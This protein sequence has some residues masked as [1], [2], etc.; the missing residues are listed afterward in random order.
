MREGIE[1]Q[2]ASDHKQLW[3]YVS[4]VFLFVTLFF[5]FVPFL[6]GMPNIGLDP[7]WQYAINQAVAQ[8]M[9]FGEDIIFTFG[10]Y[11]SI[12]TRVFHPETDTMMLLGSAYLAVCYGFVLILITT[13]KHHYWVLLLCLLMAGVM[14]SRD[15]LLF[16][17]PFILGLLSYKAF[18]EKNS[19]REKRTVFKIILFILISPLGLLPLIKGSLLILC[20]GILLLGI[21]VMVTKHYL[22]EVILAVFSFVIS[23]AFFW[24]MAGQEAVNLID[25][26]V[27]MASIIS[28]YAN[29][30]SLAGDGYE[31]VFYLLFSLL[32]LLAI[33]LNEK[34]EIDGRLYLVAVFFLFI[35]VSFKAGFIRHDG[36]HVMT[37]ASSILYLMMFYLLISYSY[38]LF[39]VV[40]LAIFV[41]MYIDSNHMA[42]SSNKVL[43]NLKQ[44]YFMSVHGF[45]KRLQNGC[46][47]CEQFLS[48]K[49]AINTKL[50]IPELDGGSDIYAYNQSYLIASDN[51]WQTRPVFQSYSAYSPVL[52]DINRDYLLSESAPD[53]IVFRLETIDNRF[54]AME[55]G[56][57]W[58]V[59][60]NSYR[61]VRR[62]KDYL[63]L[64][65][66]EKSRNGYFL[67]QLAENVHRFG[68]MIN[69]PDSDEPIFVKIDIKPSIIGRISSLFYKS[70]QVH[71]F[72]VMH[73]GS[74]KLFR[75]IPGMGSTGFMISPLVENN[76]DFIQLYGRG[77]NA[78]FSKV[79]SFVIVT[80]GF[81]L[82]CWEDAFKVSFEKLS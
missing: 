54:P 18:Y 12:Y 49:E 80:E 39:A 10:P 36:I 31:I 15:S 16:S 66:Q 45:N 64:T 76:D 43:D 77:E 68:D 37:V 50:T 74:K 59:L 63:Y 28:G 30:M 72:I 75:Y 42:T 67:Q 47:L 1:Q 79:K 2:P 19:W 9:A 61:P 55:E 26:L 13:N 32:V 25:Y 40:P 58:P 33:L 3:N 53:N 52:L 38:L 69:V 56:N 6:P 81:G 82:Q 17:Y 73:D 46:W 14:F 70:A 44:V 41:W 7:S 20:V 24:T 65:K 21:V 34:I 8:Q 35:F 23:M 22:T 78:T 29:A 11:A 27:S 51:I 71:L 60:L 48:R 57:S 4:R 5:V 62:D